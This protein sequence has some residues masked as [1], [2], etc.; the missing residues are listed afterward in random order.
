M[1]TVKLHRESR[2]F[3]LQGLQLLKKVDHAIRIVAGPISVLYA[4]VISLGFEVAAKLAEDSGYPEVRGL[5]DSNSRDSPGQDY[6]RNHRQAGQGPARG[7]A[8]RM[9][10]GDMADLMRHH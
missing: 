9:A 2:A 1:V 8:R 7:P 6:H 3:L 4:Q 5:V 10:G